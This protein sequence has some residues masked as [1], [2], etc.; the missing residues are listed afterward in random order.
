M[1]QE[2][3]VVDNVNQ[4]VKMLLDDTHAPQPKGTVNME[5][6]EFELGQWRP[7]IELGEQDMVVPRRL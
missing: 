2:L 5:K 1:C 4:A 3:L 7:S 6:T